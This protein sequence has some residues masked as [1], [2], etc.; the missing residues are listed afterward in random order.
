[1][2]WD[3]IF[4]EIHDNIEKLGLKKQFDEQLKKMKKQQHWKHIETRDQW[5][6]AND[7]VTRKYGK[8]IQ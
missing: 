2:S 5:K 8:K 4:F 1:M 6:Y 7:K 3:D